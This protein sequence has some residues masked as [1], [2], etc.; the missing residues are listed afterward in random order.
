[1]SSPRNSC[2]RA[3]RTAPS[4]RARSTA[5]TGHR[6]LPRPA[7]RRWRS[8]IPA[9]VNQA[10]GPLLRAFL[11]GA[12][13][14]ADFLARRRERLRRHAGEAAVRARVVANARWGI[15]HESEIHYDEV[16]PIGGL[17]EP[18]LLPLDTDCSGFVTLCYSWAGGP[19]PNGN[20]FSGDGYTGTM[21]AT[22]R[23]IARDEAQPGDLVVWVRR[24]GITWRS[25]SRSPPIRCSARTA[26]SGGRWRFASPSRARTSRHRRRG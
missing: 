24:P 16:R 18:R 3:T 2:S 17:T 21:L 25:C 15:A 19:D 10:F 7:A 8:G 20:G 26:R 22:C 23:P 6:A 5:N 14:P 12:E 13:L 9:G 4:S 11:Q 1:M